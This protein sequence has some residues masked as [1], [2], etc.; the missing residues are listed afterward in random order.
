MDPELAIQIENDRKATIAFLGVEGI[1]TFD[2]TMPEE[3]DAWLNIITRVFK[4]C[5]ILEHLRKD[6]A[7]TKLRGGA[8]AWCLKK[9]KL[10]PMMKWEDLY[11]ELRKINRE[12][13]HQELFKLTM[14]MWDKPEL[15]SVLDYAHR[16]K[17]E[18]LSVAPYSQCVHE[19]ARTFR[20]HLPGYLRRIVKVPF[21]KMDIDAFIEGAVQ[22]DE[23]LRNKRVPKLIG[24]PI[25]ES[26]SSQEVEGP[27]CELL[28]E[29]DKGSSFTP[30]PKRK[31]K[32]G[33]A[34][35]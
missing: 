26:N 8:L 33:R 3:Y 20:R 23:D 32:I 1:P 11:S 28:I 24:Y 21:G 9:E 34:H 18:I 31:K 19:L 2:G 14:A 7:A 10:N 4:T 16:F 12:S 29:E 27:D 13:P 15:K 22:A 17:E 25:Q 35:V 30:M 5:Q 6:L